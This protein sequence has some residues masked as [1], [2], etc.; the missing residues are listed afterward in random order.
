M[1]PNTE[2]KISVKAQRNGKLTA[3][4][5]ARAWTTTLAITGKQPV[6]APKPTEAMI[7]ALAGCMISGIQRESD[8]T[9]LQ[10]E[11]VEVT[12]EGTRVMKGKS[13]SLKNLRV[14][15]AVTSPEPED[16]LRP[17]LEA[18]NYNG[19]VTNTLKMGQPI[20]IEYKIYP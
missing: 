6:D 20:S 9:G 2:T 10:I 17:I 4:M 18:L 3:D 1:D 7:G 12:A 15:V 5:K 13:P 16:K 19:T 11:S 8:A 14:F